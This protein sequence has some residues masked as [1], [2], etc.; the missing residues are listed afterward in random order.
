MLNWRLGVI[1]IAAITISCTPRK[2]AVQ[3]GGALT[4]ALGRQYVLG[5]S[6]QRIVSLVPAV[7]E[8]LFAI[9]AGEKLVGVTQYCDYPPE[10]RDRTSVGGFSGATISMER[11]AALQPGLVL[12]SADMHARVLTLLDALDIPSF[13]VEPR[14]FSQVYETISLVGK[15]S[16]C[17][18]GAE[19]LIAE[20]KNKIELARGRINGR[21]RPAVFWIL[22]EDPLVTVGAGNFVSQAIDLGGGRNIFDD[23]PEQ[24]PMV[25][26]EQVLLRKPDW[27]FFGSDMGE[28]AALLSSNPMW[29]MILMGKENRLAEINADLFYRYGPRL[30][31]GVVY[32][33]RILHPY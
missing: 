4:D 24:W 20:M 5:E 3:V 14:D 19:N 23:I 32:I 8:I 22:S 1:L 6:P 2:P 13:A 15:L 16:G 21:E 33:S 18:I 28:S 29:Q 26:H 27:V 17:E 9:G 12:L 7:T 30:A 10:A 31:D 25:S 11:V